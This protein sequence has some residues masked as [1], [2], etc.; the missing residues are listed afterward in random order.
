MCLGLLQ[1]TT[2]RIKD[3]DILTTANTVELESDERWLSLS[4]NQL[5]MCSLTYNTPKQP[6]VKEI[7]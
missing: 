5:Q 6:Q 1:E 2:C 4:S 3:V 7:D